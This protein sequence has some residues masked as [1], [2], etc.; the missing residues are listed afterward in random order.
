MEYQTDPQ[1]LLSGEDWR[2]T[3]Q[4]NAQLTSEESFGDSLF[5]AN[6]LDVPNLQQLLDQNL[7]QKEVIGQIAHG[8]STLDQND[9]FA[10]LPLEILQE[11]LLYL[12]S[13][14][15]LNLKLTSAVVT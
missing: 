12:P 4:L 3:G 7:N 2:L 13:K 15:V 1:S 6:P 14:D 5:F 8:Y 10:I 9:C 11:I